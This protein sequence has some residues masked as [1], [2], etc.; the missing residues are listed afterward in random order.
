MWSGS[1]MVPSKEATRLA[2]LLISLM[3]DI[4]IFQSDGKHLGLAP[5]Q[6]EQGDEIVLFDKGNVP[7][8]LRRVPEEEYKLVGPL[9]V[10]GIMD[11]EFFLRQDSISVMFK[12]R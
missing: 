10:D 11:G 2:N 4:K 8:L 9:Y 7:F 1:I 6:A 3:A 12:L 5:A